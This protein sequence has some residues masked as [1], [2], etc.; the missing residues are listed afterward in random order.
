M[1]KIFYF[2]ADM[3]E[4]FLDVV[5]E[6]IDCIEESGLYDEI[7]Q[8][9]V[10][11]A[12][13][14]RKHVQKLKAMLPKKFKLCYFSRINQYELPAMHMIK[15]YT[16]P[17]DKILYLHTKG[18]SKSGK[19]RIS[20]DKWREYLN[21]GC[22]EKY[23]SHIAA[24]SLF[25]VSGVQLTRL[26][27]NFAQKCG[28]GLVYAGNYF[29]ANGY[30]I[31]KLKAPEIGTNRWIAEG[32]LFGAN[33]KAYDAHNLTGGEMITMNNT[34]NLP[35]FNRKVY[36][37]NYVEKM[38]GMI[39]W[40]YDIINSLIAKFNYKTY[41]EIGIW[42]LTCFNK[43]KCDLKHSVDPM[44][45]NAIFKMTSDEFFK[46]NKNKYDIFFIDGLHT[47]EQVKRD[48][49]NALEC[50]E[51]GGTIVCHDMIPNTEWEARSTKAFDSEG[52]WN[53]DC[54]KAW[55]E[56]R[57]TRHDLSMYVIDADWGCGIIRK[58]KQKT[59]P[60][61]TKDD[62]KTYRQNTKEIMNTVEPE[63]FFDWLG[64]LK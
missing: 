24:L 43:V 25:D 13:E 36:D 64:E 19:W 34:F 58:G 28:S 10:C 38:P 15:Q 5:R 52:I 39:Q 55:I 57:K 8:G 42:T 35:S 54:Y 7:G 37:K 47:C 40:R 2:V 26:N 14:N 49:E 33:P 4:D 11:L 61:D 63:K 60:A 22:I 3:S 9:Y 1:L 29:W 50:L 45:N 17:E 31:Q 56:L 16:N 20:A 44:V 21:W 32:W 6:Q 62:F 53:G 41:L 59:L 23:E 51:P 46:Q 27:D 18:V 48:I 30:Y 12:S